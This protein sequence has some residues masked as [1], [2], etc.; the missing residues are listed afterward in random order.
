MHRVKVMVETEETTFFGGKKK[1][2]KKSGSKWM[3]KPMS[4]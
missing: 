4:V 2:C 3:T 1:S